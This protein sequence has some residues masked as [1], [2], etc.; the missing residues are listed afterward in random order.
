MVTIGQ[1]QPLWSLQDSCNLAGYWKVWPVVLGRV[2]GEIRRGF[3]VTEARAAAMCLF[4]R[5]AHLGPRAKDAA[6]RRQL[7]FRLEERRR[8][9]KAYSMAQSV[10]E[11]PGSGG[12]LRK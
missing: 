10:G 1:L 9:R 8:K 5:P 4:E 2:T 7:T 11:L 6:L 3:S 12:T